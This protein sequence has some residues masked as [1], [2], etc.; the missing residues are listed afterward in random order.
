MREIKI[1][2]KTLVVVCILSTSA[3]NAQFAI[4][5]KLGLNSSTQEE[6]GKIYYNNDFLVGSQAG[7]LIDY[8]FHSVFSLQ[9]EGN[10]ITKGA[11]T[12]L[13]GAYNSNDVCRKFEYINVPLLVKARFGSQLGLDE[14]CGLFL[15]AGPYYSKLLVAKDY[16]NS[17]DISEISNI[18]TDANSLDTGLVFGGGFSY[19]LNNRHEVFFDVRYDMGLSEV[20]TSD[21]DLRNKTIGFSMGYSFF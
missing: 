3:A 18:E 4:G 21:T 17:E 1:C 11:K 8:R 7:I 6:L 19:L 5:G 9:A 14:K 12:D 15:Y 2:F 13:N 16:H 10:Y 20:M